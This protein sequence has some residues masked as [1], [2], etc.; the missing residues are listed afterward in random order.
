MEVDEE[1]P[2]GW[3]GWRMWN[4]MVIDDMSHVANP[5]VETRF[6]GQTHAESSWEGYE[7]M[8]DVDPVQDAVMQTGNYAA[9]SDGR[10]Y[11]RN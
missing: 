5:D 9:I 11:Y 6:P 1:A 2:G 7:N 4:E 3:Q 10:W 8:Y